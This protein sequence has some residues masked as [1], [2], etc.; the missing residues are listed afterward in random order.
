MATER[1]TFRSRSSKGRR[2]GYWLLWPSARPLHFLK[3]QPCLRCVAD[4]AWS[5][6]RS[7]ARPRGHRPA[8][9]VARSRETKAEARAEALS[10]A[11]AAAA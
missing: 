5:P 2:I 8:A 11:D 3:P 4:A 10:F 6:R 9:A 7:A 1:A